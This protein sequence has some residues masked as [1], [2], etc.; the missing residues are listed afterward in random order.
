VER[1]SLTVISSAIGTLSIQMN[2][3]PTV[4]RSS[5]SQGLHAILIGGR[6]CTQTT[7][8]GEAVEGRLAGRGNFPLRPAELLPFAGHCQGLLST[9]GPSRPLVEQL[10]FRQ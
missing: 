8:S 9:A 7:S 5:E 2:G 1:F 10:T 3:T 6:I 4:I